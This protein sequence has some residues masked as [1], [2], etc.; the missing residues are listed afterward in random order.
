MLAAPPLLLLVVIVVIN[1]AAAAA[2]AAAFDE[3]AA[4]DDDDDDDVEDEEVEVAELPPGVA[5][6][7]VGICIDSH[8]KS[9]AV[10]M[11]GLLAEE[12]PADAA[13]VVDVSI[14]NR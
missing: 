5:T 8:L 9:I 2:A 10:E 4:A 3:A 14:W 6:F 1:V 7:P 12:P 11:V 13:A